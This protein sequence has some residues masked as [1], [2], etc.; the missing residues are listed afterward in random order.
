MIFFRDIRILLIIISFEI[1]IFGHSIHPSN[2][3]ERCKEENSCQ[4]EKKLCKCDAKC[5]E[6]GDCCH[7]SPYS[8]NSTQKHKTLCVKNIYIKTH[9][10]P[11]W[12]DDAMRRKCENYSELSDPLSTVPVTSLD[13]AETFRNY[14]CAVC[15]DVTENFLFWTVTVTCPLKHAH[16]HLNLEYLQNH[17]QYNPTADS[18]GVWLSNDRKV[19]RK[20]HLD[21]VPESYHIPDSLLRRCSYLI[22]TCYDS[23][24]NSELEKNCTEYHAPVFIGGIGYDNVYCA[25]CNEVKLSEISCKS[26]YLFSS[27]PPHY[28]NPQAFHNFQSDVLKLNF[29]SC[30]ESHVFDPFFKKCRSL[31]N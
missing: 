24:Q 17:L 2:N 5:P 31:F 20:C 23:W 19:F 28:I 6:Y 10:L 27:I 22:S 25:M 11:T 1:L 3:E 13:N 9:C 4:N 26:P 30:G 8:N 7:D 15:N 21:F 12:D 29:E 18:W 14:Y 16:N